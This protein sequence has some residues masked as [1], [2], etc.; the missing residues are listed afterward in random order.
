MC[1]LSGC[2]CLA[3]RGVKILFRDGVRC[4][5]DRYVGIGAHGEMTGHIGGDYTGF[6]NS[7]Y[8][9]S[10]NRYPEYPGSRGALR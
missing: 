5:R 7:D 9:S 10:I 2:L 8:Q 1:T 6:G 4:C 3:L